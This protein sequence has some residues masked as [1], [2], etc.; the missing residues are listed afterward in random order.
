MWFALSPYLPANEAECGCRIIF[1]FTNND[2]I[3][4]KLIRKIHTIIQIHNG[5]GTLWKKSIILLSK[6]S[7]CTIEEK[8]IMSPSRAVHIQ[9]A[10]FRLCRSEILGEGVVVELLPS[11]P[12]SR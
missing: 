11:N 2:N 4:I 1:V 7:N 5:N 12:C 8:K 10:D 3:Y 6:Y 9:V